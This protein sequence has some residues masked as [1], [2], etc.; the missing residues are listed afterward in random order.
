MGILYNNSLTQRPSFDELKQKL[1]YATIELGSL[2]VEA[3]EEMRK[4]KEDVN[5]LINLLKMAYQERDEAKGQLQKLVNKLKLSSAT[6]LLPILPQAQPE[7][8][9]VMPARAN[10]SIT[11][12]N[13]L[14]DTYNHQSHGSSPVDSLFDAVTSPDFSNINMADS[15]HMGFVNKTLVQDYDGSVP[16]GLV[17]PAVAKIDPAD[18]VIDKFV[19]GKV[20]PENGKLLPAVMETAPLLQTLLLAGPLPRWRNPPP[21]HPFKIPPVSISGETPNLTANSSCLAQQPLA[22]PSYIELSRGSSQICSASLLDFATGA[23]G[24]GIDNGRLL[25]SG[26][27]HQIAACKRQRFQ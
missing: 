11:E 4:H 24:S 25:N 3:N 27:I 17:A 13:S 1:V 10:S 8:P 19:K 14:S 7:S 18:V 26:A 12:S 23:S 21:L 9:L 6:G 2:K 5:H 20:L 22:S 16:T 15:C